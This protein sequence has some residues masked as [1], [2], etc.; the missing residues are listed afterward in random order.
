MSQFERPN[1]AALQG[2]SSGE[3]PLEKETIKLN[4]NENPFPVSVKVQAAL[5]DFATADLRVYPQPTADKL[6]DAIAAHHGL[7]RDHVIVTHA[8]DEA[9]RLAITTFVEPGGTL[10]TTEPSYSLYPVLSKIQDA[11]MHTLAL[12]DD[13]SIPSEFAQTITEHNA[14][15]TCLV[16]PHAP[17]GHLTPLQSIESIAK[18]ISGVLLVDEAYIDFVDPDLAYSSKALINAQDNVL[19]LRTFSKG[20]SL[21][22]LRLGYLLGDPELIKPMLEKTRDSYNVDGISQ[23]LGLAAISDQDYAKDTWRQVREQRQ[24]LG[25]ALVA[26]GFSCPHSEANFLL[27]TTP[28]EIDAEGLY[29]ALKAKG[30]LV[31]F[32]PTPRL[33]DKLRI[34]IGTAEQNEKLIASIRQLI[35]R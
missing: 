25:D 20:Y 9:L 8:G 27:A 21:A 28:E 19:V 16:N 33:K 24:V 17:S 35:T 5:M 30:I 4:T 7:T 13:W 23:A 26:L 29:E 14:Q 2:Y 34:T 11:N 1:I 15:L 3:Q 10:G 18:N 12:H 32:F 6:R 22:G 31:R